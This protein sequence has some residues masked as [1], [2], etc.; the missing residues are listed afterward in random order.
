[1]QVDPHHRQNSL[2]LYSK[3]ILSHFSPKRMFTTS[4]S[5]AYFSLV[6]LE[7]HHVHPELITEIKAND[8]PSCWIYPNTFNT[9]TIYYVLCGLL[10]KSSV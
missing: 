8:A 3:L 4:H 6:M 2:S 10:S 5:N 1:M 9:C 7:F